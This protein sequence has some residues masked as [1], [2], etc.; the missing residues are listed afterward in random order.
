MYCKH[1][2]PHSNEKMPGW[3]ILNAQKSSISVGSEF[4]MG[5]QVTSWISK[6]TEEF[7]YRRQIHL[8]NTQT[9]QRRQL[10]DEGYV[11]TL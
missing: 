9:S 10:L 5:R 4:E 8:S 7:R 11:F 2:T 6:T 1:S 3:S